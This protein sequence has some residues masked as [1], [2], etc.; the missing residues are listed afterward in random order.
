MSFP[1]I[2]AAPCLLTWRRLSSLQKIAKPGEPP[3][4]AVPQVAPPRQSNSLV[5][6]YHAHDTG[7]SLRLRESK[8]L[9]GLLLEGVGDSEWKR[10]IFDENVLQ[11]ERASSLRRIVTLLRSRLDE[12]DREGWRMIC[13]GDRDLAVQTLF[14]GAIKHSRLI[15]D[16]LDLAIRDQKQLFARVLEAHVWAEYVEGCRARD[17][18]LE[19]WADLTSDKLRQVVCN[20]L[21]EVGFLESVRNPEFRTVFVV[22][23]LEQYLRDRE[24]HYVLRCMEVMG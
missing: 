1:Q 14:A 20:M 24:E 8:I 23:E 22:P 3:R 12:L 10:V 5:L 16:F 2:E 18:E 9:A 7:A 21:V 13:E 15:G 4:S 17:V 6:I 11:I 19:H